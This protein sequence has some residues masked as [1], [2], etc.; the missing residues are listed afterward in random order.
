MKKLTSLGFTLILLFALAVT[1]SADLTPPLWQQCAYESYEA[2]LDSKGITAAQY[3]KLA[4]EA[5]T[6]DAYA[7]YDRIFADYFGAADAF[8]SANEMSEEDFRLLML[9]NWAVEAAAAYREAN[10]LAEQRTADIIAAGGAPGALNV[11]FNGTCI[12]FPG[13]AVPEMANNR[14]MVP[15]RAAMEY[16][17]CT[18]D[19]APPTRT[20]SV[21][22]GEVSFTHVIGA[23]TIT[24]SDGTAVEMDVPS[25]IVSGRTMVPLRFFSQ[26]LG[27]D[28][29]WDGALRTAVIVDK[30]A[31]IETFDKEFTVLNGFLAKLQETA[32]TDPTKPLAVDLAFS[33]D[34]SYHDVSGD[35]DLGLSG[36]LSLLA[37]GHVVNAEGRMDLSDLIDL[38]EQA[39][40]PISP[41]EAALF[42]DLSFRLI[43][44]DE[45]LYL[46]API[47]SALSFDVST[48]GGMIYESAKAAHAE[49]PFYL[50]AALVEDT[51]AAILGDDAFTRRGSSYRWRFDGDD[52]KALTGYSIA[53]EDLDALELT[54]V[55]HDSGRLQFTGLIE[56][57]GFA[58]ELGLDVDG[59]DVDLALS[60][61]EDSVAALR[62]TLAGATRESSERPLAAPGDGA[63]VI[64]ENFPLLPKEG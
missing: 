24:L 36:E 22:G 15:L 4:K 41:A 32:K 7:Y 56:G 33:G 52:Y 59:G 55:L 38:M 19:Y 53:V 9:Q 14:T 28:V 5:E 39:G 57:G 51:A 43:L 47:L 11:M 61:S 26:V 1:A 34:L 44:G 12:P 18:V 25:Y 54:A 6:F 16:L 49:S 64:D 46:S 31:V 35:L 23:K 8:K 17:G 50:Y 27:Y 20:A 37:L 48:V 13:A 29:F 42:S 63:P 10:E 60:L 21:S 2:C 58:L 3:D 40:E 62:F 30:D 45:T